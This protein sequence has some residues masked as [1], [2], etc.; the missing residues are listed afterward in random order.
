MNNTNNSINTN[1]KIINIKND[2][3]NLIKFI[4]ENLEIYLNYKDINNSSLLTYKKSILK[5]L[6]FIRSTKINSID[7]ILLNFKNN[8]KD[9]Y[10]FNS[11]NLFLTCIKNFFKYFKDNDLVNKINLNIKNFKVDTKH[12]KKCLDDTEIKKINQNLDNE[13]LRNKII[14]K[15]ML[16]TGARQIE[17]YRANVKDLNNNLLYIQGKFKVDKNDFL[18]L[19][20]DILIDIKNYLKIRNNIKKDEPLFISNSNNSKGSRLSLKSIR[21]IIK[22][23]YKKN[24]ILDPKKTTHSLR[25]TAITKLL[26]LGKKIENVMNFARHQSINTTLIYNHSINKIKDNFENC[27]NEIFFKNDSSTNTG[28]VKNDLDDTENNLVD[29]STNF[30]NNIKDYI[31]NLLKNDSSTNN[32]FDNLDYIENSFKAKKGGF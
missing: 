25:H 30:L 2:K 12:K 4:S 1:N 16:T 24:D 10:N 27:L 15:I 17:L 3:N 18:I 28:N 8:L 26:F 7:N 6:D 9:N 20:N 11:S 14:Y 21:N 22:N 13:I 32:L 29:S 23:I 31:K 5:F 19:S